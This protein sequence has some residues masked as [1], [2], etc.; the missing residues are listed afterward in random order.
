MIRRPLSRPAVRTE[1]NAPARPSPLAARAG[2]PPGSLLPPETGGSS[3]AQSHWSGPEA[4][5]P[6][7]ST[8]RLKIVLGVK[9]KCR[10]FGTTRVELVA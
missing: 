8:L 9:R 6:D 5:A 10:T 7:K 4:S 3:E 2:C 1:R